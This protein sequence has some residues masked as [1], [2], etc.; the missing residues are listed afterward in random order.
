MLSC[1]P[2]RSCWKLR[3]QV[4]Q[5]TKSTLTEKID[6]LFIGVW[7]CGATSFPMEPRLNLPLPQPTGGL[8]VIEMVGLAVSFIGLPA[9][10]EWPSWSVTLF[11]FEDTALDLG[12][13]S[14]VK[15]PTRKY[16]MFRTFEI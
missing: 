4:E 2:I 16:Q 7:V 8:V 15:H 11:R 14:A 10:L 1:F 12:E 5:A 13:S 3:L 9:L 6:F